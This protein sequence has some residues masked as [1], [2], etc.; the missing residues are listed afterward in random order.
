MIL[1]ANQNVKAYLNIDISHQMIAHVIT[2]VHLF[3]DTIL[4]RKKGVKSTNALN[5]IEK[6]Y[7]ARKQWAQII[8]SY[9]FLIVHIHNIDCVYIF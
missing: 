7:V 2:Y 8:Q 9:V 4:K 1:L 3:D 5:T 6:N